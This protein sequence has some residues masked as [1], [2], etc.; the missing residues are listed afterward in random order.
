MDIA[1]AVGLVFGLACI[2][3]AILSKGAEQAQGFVDIGSMTIVLGG[4]IAATFIHFQMK[5]VVG[6]VG[7]MKKTLF[8]QLPPEQELIQKMVNYSAINRRDGALALEQQLARAGDGFLVRA[9]QMVID[10]QTPEIMEEQ[11]GMEI[12]N[13]QERHADGKKLLEFMG[14]AAPAWGM[15]GTLIGLVQMLSALDDPANIGSG[16]A[17]ALI[18]TFYGA[19]L[20]NLVFLPL[21]GKLGLKSKRESILRQMTVVGV[22]G[23]AR[24]D[25]PTGVRERMQTFVSVKHRADLKPKI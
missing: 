10:G 25:S 4:T 23:L 8:Y 16:M 7:V 19:F 18:T 15:I 13:L 14:S 21:A 20:A 6:I 12:Q 5:Q 22:L 11:L 2:A 24:G 17:T 3:W 9:L 1:T